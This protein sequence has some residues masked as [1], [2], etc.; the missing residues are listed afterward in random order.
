MIIIVVGVIIGGLVISMFL[1]IFNL[2]NIV[3]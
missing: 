3:Q 1:P 2:A